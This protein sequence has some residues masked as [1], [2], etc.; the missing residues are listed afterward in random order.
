M[1]VMLHIIRDD[2]KPVG[3]HSSITHKPHFRYI[4][5]CGSAGFNSIPLNF[6]AGTLFEYP[7]HYRQYLLF[8]GAI[9][10]LLS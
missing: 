8:L 5:W 10:S 7:F 6:G 2:S 1:I 4:T 9:L 3:I